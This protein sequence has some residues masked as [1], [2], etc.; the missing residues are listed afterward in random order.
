MTAKRRQPTL[1]RSASGQPTGSAAQ[2]RLAAQRALVAA[3]EARTARRH[4]ILLALTPVLVVVLVVAA[5][6]VVRV[7]SGSSKPKS[8]VAATSAAAQVTAAV[9]GVPESALD[10]V[11]KGTLTTPPTALTGAALTADGLPRILFVGAE[12]CP[13]CAAERW[14]LAVALSRFGTLSGLGEVSSSSTDSYPNTATLTF[15]GATYTSQYLSL[16]AK[17]IFSNQVSG[18]SY[19][20]LD[21]LDS[22]DEALF[23]S[24]GGGSFPF[25]DIGGKYKISGASY[26]PQILQGLTQAQIAAALSD[27]TSAI[28]K[29]IDGTANVITAAICTVTGN[30]PAA[31]CTS[32]GVVAAKAALPSS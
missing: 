10:T 8:G 29:A 20:A 21:T 1:S 15:H 2:K 19:A 30:Q 13:Y 22:A 6:V 18:T 9:T 25:I 24:V 4:R 12:W 28:A 26:D 3:S 14:A 7:S 31:V 17:E 27:P 32:A 11:G 5:L 16:T 23:T